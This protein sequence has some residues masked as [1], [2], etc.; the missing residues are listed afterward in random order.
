[1]LTALIEGTYILQIVRRQY[2][3]L[4]RVYTLHTYLAV[5]SIT[6]QT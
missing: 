4:L 6:L 5:R 2:I 1:M 3:V